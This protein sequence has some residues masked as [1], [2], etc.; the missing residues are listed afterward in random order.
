MSTEANSSGPA[1][2]SE[3]LSAIADELRSRASRLQTDAPQPDSPN[4]RPNQ[5][6]R[7]AKEFAEGGRLLLEA[8][9][10]GAFANDSLMG[11]LIS[12]YRNRV[13]HKEKQGFRDALAY[14]RLELFLAFE[15]QWLPQQRPN[16][17]KEL[18]GGGYSIHN[19]E[20][21]AKVM[22]FLAQLVEETLEATSMRE[23]EGLTL[24]QSKR[25]SLSPEDEAKVFEKCLR[26]C[27]VCF[28]LEN[29]DS[30]QDGQLAHLDHNH[31]NGDPTNFVFLCLRHHN[32]YDSK[33]SQAKNMT[34]REMRLYQ[35][36]LHQAVERGEV[37]R[38]C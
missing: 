2:P 26:R 35:Q 28:V 1:P 25:R 11:D 21:Y 5:S 29:N 16:M 32:I 12:G 24:S 18:D 36:K 15:Q 30:Q 31:S 19:Y 22:V 8:V 17:A 37:P 27:C 9:E 14:S 7:L 13:E 10:A 6:K 23:K 20:R 33:M 38:R 3:R 4:N 34:E